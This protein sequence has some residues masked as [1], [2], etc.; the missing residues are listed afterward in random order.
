M[1]RI[2]VL[3]M[4][5]FSNTCLYADVFEDKSTQLREF[6]KELNLPGLC[7][8]DDLEENEIANAQLASLAALMKTNL[9]DEEDN[10]NTGLALK[11]KSF[12]QSHSKTTAALSAK[13]YLGEYLVQSAGNLIKSDDNFRKVLISTAS[14]IHNMYSDIGKQFPNR[15]QGKYSTCITKELIIAD[16]LEDEE[17]IIAKFRKTLPKIKDFENDPEFVKYKNSIGLEKT[18]MEENSR[19]GIIYL[20]LKLNKKDVAIQEFNNFKSL[21]PSSIYI[22]ELEPLFLDK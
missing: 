4:V 13:L 15:W 19:Y 22:K 9:E 1:N 11:F 8:G 18:S 14:N 2:L 17:A 21:F 16:F 10:Y 20:L 7:V 12:I 5:L 3:V 6:Y